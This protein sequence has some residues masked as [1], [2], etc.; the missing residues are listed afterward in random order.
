MRNGARRLGLQ[1]M[2]LLRY[3]KLPCGTPPSHLFVHF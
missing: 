1:R 2:Y 3:G